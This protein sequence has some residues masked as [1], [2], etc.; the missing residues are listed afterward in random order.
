MKTTRPLLRFPRV[1][2]ALAALLLVVTATVSAQVV[3]VSTSTSAPTDNLL[4]SFSESINAGIAWRA[5]SRDEVTSENWRDVG[6]LF[7]APQDATLDAITV[8]TSSGVNS[9]ARGVSFTLTLYSFGTS[10]STANA[11]VIQTF[12]GSTPSGTISSGTFLAFD[13]PDVQLTAGITYGFL[14]HFD[15]MIDNR[16]IPLRLNNSSNAFAEGRL[17]TRVNSYDTDGQLVSLGSL[18]TN[19]SSLE[20]YVQATPIPEPATVAALF[21]L[22]VL[23]LG[24]WRHRARSPRS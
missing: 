4:I 16:S 12:T 21:G 6:Q 11:E 9:P 18:S 24:L 23:A 17:L 5:D 3:T 10:F 19:T 8:V 7:T 13:L 2:P 1:L 14:L 20:F 22:A 15:A